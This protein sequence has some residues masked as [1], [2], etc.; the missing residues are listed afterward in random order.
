MFVILHLEF[1][2]SHF[3]DFFFT[4]YEDFVDFFC[5]GSG[6]TLPWESPMFINKDNDKD[7]NCNGNNNNNNNNKTKQ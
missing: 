2:N 5:I 4:E 3:Y 6:H 7:N 1:S